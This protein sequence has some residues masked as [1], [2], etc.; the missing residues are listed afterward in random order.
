MQSNSSPTTAAKSLEDR[1]INLESYVAF[2]ERTLAILDETVREFTQRI[3][4][5]E[6]EVHRLR[7]F[8]N[9]DD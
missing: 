6:K 8:A 4:T 5:L 3:E 9:Y 1:V 2:Q 7:E